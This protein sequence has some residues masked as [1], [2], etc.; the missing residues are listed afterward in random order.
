MSDK[1]KWIAAFLL[2]FLFASFITVS[3]DEDKGKQEEAFKKVREISKNSLVR[4]KI[5][6]RDPNGIVPPIL[7]NNDMV[8]SW[9][10]YWQT[11]KPTMNF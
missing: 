6:F 11:E 5:F 3:A 9:K 8:S 2:I 10:T 1:S 7:I 4:V